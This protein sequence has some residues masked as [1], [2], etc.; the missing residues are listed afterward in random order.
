[1][2]N[3]KKHIAGIGHSIDDALEVCARYGI[4][5]GNAV[6]VGSVLRGGS[7]GRTFA[8]YILQPGFLPPPKF[9][10]SFDPSLITNSHPR[11]SVAELETLL[12]EARER[13]AKW[14]KLFP[15]IG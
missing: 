4:P 6:S 5:L 14:A 2:V 9:W 10:Q 11:F 1:V 15:T 12:A 13:E 7:R 3:T 8:G